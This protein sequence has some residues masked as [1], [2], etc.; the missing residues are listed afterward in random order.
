MPEKKSK[1]DNYKEINKR[2][3]EGIHGETSLSEADAKDIAQ[4][5]KDVVSEVNKVVRG[6]DD[7][8]KDV[9]LCLMCDSHA[10]LEGVPGLAKSLMVETISKVIEGTSFNR[11]QFLPDLL[12]SDILGGEIYEPKTGTFK[13]F[14]GPI[15][16]NFILADEINRAPPKTHAALMETMQEE[17]VNIG[18]D[19]FIL[20]KPFLVLATENPLES[21]GTYALPDAIVDRFMFK[22]MLD[23]PPRD[24]EKIIITENATTNRNIED[25]VNTILTKKEVMEIQKKVKKVF[26]ADRIRD[27]ILDII[28]ATRGKK[29]DITGVQFVKYGGSPRA[30]IYL[31][32]GAKAKAL[33][34]GRNYVL[35]EDVRFVAPN[36]LRH[37]IQLNYKG[38][39]HDIST[40]KII[41]EILKIIKSV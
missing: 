18:S 22:I 6:Q 38:K 15:F 36:V 17:K 16:A 9:L 7:N 13:V 24:C 41:D 33:F 2:Y 4:K 11:I 20:D 26:L 30:S 12:P 34:E 25:N 28:E 29:K 19:E 32:I 3:F 40:E 21:E 27:Y 39:A 35:P 10:L 31:G 8:I 14:K 1:G 5:I 37:R 23:Y